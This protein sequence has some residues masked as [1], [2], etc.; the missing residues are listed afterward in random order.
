M[1]VPRIRTVN[2]R[3]HFRIPFGVGEVALIVGEPTLDTVCAENGVGRRRDSSL[4]VGTPPT[5]TDLSPFR[6][7]RMGRPIYCHHHSGMPQQTVRV[8]LIGVYSPETPEC[9]HSKGYIWIIGRSLFGGVVL[10]RGSGR[11]WEKE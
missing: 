9:T 2:P 4:A 8:A 6:Y 11:G 5:R 10:H 7:V 1:G 3:T